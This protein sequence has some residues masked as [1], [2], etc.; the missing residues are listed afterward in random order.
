MASD[1]D[2]LGAAYWLL[3]VVTQEFAQLAQA[4]GARVQVEVFEGMW[5]D[6]I[7]ESEGCGS[8]EP[9]VEAQEALQAA[10][11]FLNAT[12]YERGGCKVQCGTAP[13]DPRSTL[14][15]GQ[16]EREQG[17][18]LVTGGAAVVHWHY[19]YNYKPPATQAD[20]RD[21]W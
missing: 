13:I 18:T 9:L 4:A 5:H 6:F 7:Q 14:R 10:A 19:R 8:G 11:T 3:A 17:G 12:S 2:L 15:D 16:R 20:C 1:R 21:I